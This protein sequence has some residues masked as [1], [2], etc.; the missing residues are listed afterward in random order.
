MRFGNVVV[1]SRS[2]VSLCRVLISDRC[3]MCLCL[4]VVCV[5][6]EGEPAAPERKT[7][8]VV[9]KKEEKKEE[10]DVKAVFSFT[11]PGAAV[12]ESNNK[13]LKAKLRPE[14]A[15]HGVVDEIRVTAVDESTD[16]EILIFFSRLLAKGLEIKNKIDASEPAKLN[17]LAQEVDVT[18]SEATPS[19]GGNTTNTH[20]HT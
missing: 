8:A 4:R 19:G 18:L 15:G 13:Q 17:I 20:T 11:L 16:K 12:G 2:V 3:C 9:E 10:G 14:F 6:V 7:K 1:S 5:C